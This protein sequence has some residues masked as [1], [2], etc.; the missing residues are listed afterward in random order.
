M[1]IVNNIDLSIV[2]PVYNS[3]KNLEILINQLIVSLKKNYDRYEIILVDDE[4]KDKS[5]NVIKN[6]CLKYDFIRGIQL[7]NNV[8]QHNAIFAGLKYTNGNFIITM[9]DD[10]QNSP[11]D[12][13]LLVDKV[14]NGYDVSYANYKN[15]KHNIFRIF[16]SYINNLF[17][18]FLFN[19]PVN[20]ILT[21]FRCLNN[22]IKIE[23]LKNKSST[24][25]LDG[26]IFSITKNISNVYVEHKKREHGKSNYTIYKL[27]GLWSQMATGFSILPLRIS[28]LLGFFF[29]ILSF[30]VTIWFVF[31]RSI[32]SLIPTGWTSLIVVI[33]FFGGIQLLAL[34]LIGEYIGKTYLTVNNSIQYSEKSKINIKS[35]DKT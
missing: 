13:K 17:A 19:K 31:F 15:K 5:W 16:G 25:Y 21:S 28:S 7:R 27:I 2:I 3:E 22:D 26:L 11:E 1:S 18:S 23:I 32:D 9:D 10:G 33:I 6:I 4:S 24:L 8:G 30:F 14:K 20:L 29:S 34:G 35:K 12:I